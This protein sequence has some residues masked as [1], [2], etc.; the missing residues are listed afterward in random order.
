M[1]FSILLYLAAVALRMVDEGTW[2]VFLPVAL[3][4]VALGIVGLLRMSS[5]LRY[6]EGKIAFL[7]VL[8]FVPLVGF[9]MLAIVNDEATKTLRAGGYK[10]GLFGA[11]GRPAS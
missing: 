11:R 2:F 8:A 1:I 5:G 4:S 3:V 9:V 6:S 10:V 7:I